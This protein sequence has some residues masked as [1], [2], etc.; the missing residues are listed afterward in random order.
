MG[1]S[2]AANE[3]MERGNA[4]VLSS[5]ELCPGAA[6]QWIYGGG[7]RKGSPDS[8]DGTALAAINSGAVVVTISYRVGI[9]GFL[10]P[11]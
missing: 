3:W 2:T 5:D 7:F 4:R 6:L 11:G 8:Y 1:L 9:F 10:G